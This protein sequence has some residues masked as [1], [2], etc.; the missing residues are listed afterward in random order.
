[1]LNQAADSPVSAETF[2]ARIARYAADKVAKARD[3]AMAAASLQAPVSEETLLAGGGR[4]V[5]HVGHTDEL[6]A[7]S[8]L[9][10]FRLLL[11][12]KLLP[13]DTQ[14]WRAAPK[15]AEE[16][17][18]EPPVRFPPRLISSQVP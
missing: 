17:G 11:G 2:S 13:R 10:A 5:L 4:W 9:K 12:V 6:I 16:E 8:F 18:F 3:G 14:F 1:M 15:L 7:P